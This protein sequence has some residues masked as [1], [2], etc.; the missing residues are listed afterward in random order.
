MKMTIRLGVLLLLVL[1]LSIVHAEIRVDCVQGCE[2]PGANQSVNLL[3]RKTESVPVVIRWAT[4]ENPQA[5]GSILTLYAGNPTMQAAIP[6]R[7]AVT[8]SATTQG[9]WEATRQFPGTELGRGTFLAVVTQRPKG[10]EQDGSGKDE[11]IVD[12]RAFRLLTTAEQRRKEQG[13]PPGGAGSVIVTPAL[14]RVSSGHGELPPARGGDKQAWWS[15]ADMEGDTSDL[16][17]DGREVGVPGLTI[18][19]STPWHSSATENWKD[20][21]QQKLTGVNGHQ[22]HF[23]D[24]EWYEQPDRTIT[25]GAGQ[26]TLEVRH[27]YTVVTLFTNATVKSFDDKEVGANHWFLSPTYFSH[28]TSARLKHPDDPRFWASYSLREYSADQR[29]LGI[30]QRHVARV[31]TV[32]GLGIVQRSNGDGGV[33]LYTAG[34]YATVHPWESAAESGPKSA[35]AGF[36]GLDVRAARAG[37]GRLVT[38][39]SAGTSTLERV[40]CQVIRCGESGHGLDMDAPPSGYQVTQP[41]ASLATFSGELPM[42]QE[43]PEIAERGLLPEGTDTATDGQKAPDVLAALP[44]RVRFGISANFRS[45]ALLQEASW[46]YIAN[47]VP[48]NTYAQFVV[49]MTVAMVPNTNMVTNDEQIMPLP[50]ELATRIAVPKPTG[51]WAWLTEHPLV[52]IA[53][54]AGGIGLVLVFVPGGLPLLRSIMGVITQALQL[55]VDAISLLLKKLA[56]L[57]QRKSGG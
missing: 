26:Q 17:P 30:L 11:S 52:W 12:W 29:L 36:V 21:V 41:V 22:V 55:V 43:R 54:L 28:E 34:F 56:G 1:W 40:W 10:S 35:R 47:I 42:I 37:I 45:G 8:F 4:N 16:D 7:G 38:E 32:P 15:L 44:T 50:V 9:E 19:V 39:G 27:Y 2:A 33:S 25:L 51:L 14:L 48:I 23:G 18:Q 49:K 57:I 53:A 13:P 24:I 5:E 46:G 31:G 3:L 6:D 20:T